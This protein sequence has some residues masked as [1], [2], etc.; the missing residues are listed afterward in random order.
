M[1]IILVV[2]SFLIDLF[3]IKTSGTR[4]TFMGLGINVTETANGIETMFG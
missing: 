3:S 4:V 1:W 2:G